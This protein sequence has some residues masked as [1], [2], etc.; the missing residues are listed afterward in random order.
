MMSP[1]K[2]DVPTHLGIPRLPQELLHPTS[3]CPAT[4]SVHSD[5]PGANKPSQS[6]PLYTELS[7]GE[8]LLIAR[9]RGWSEQQSARA[10]TVRIAEILRLIENGQFKVS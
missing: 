1:I 6:N 9:E 8:F 7:S 3:T 10:Y 5:N 2:L 4:A